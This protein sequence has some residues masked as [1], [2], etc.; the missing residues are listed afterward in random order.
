MHF[1]VC[2]ELVIRVGNWK[3]SFCVLQAL[4]C[5]KA[6]SKHLPPKGKSQCLELVT[7]QVAPDGLVKC[8]C[9][10]YIACMN[11]C[12]SVCLFVYVC[13]HACVHVHA[14]KTTSSGVDS[15]T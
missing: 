8:I 10:V 7:K 3:L 9:V 13:V 15:Q 12:V 4:K 6:L 1:F 11:V 14:C 5:L 2:G